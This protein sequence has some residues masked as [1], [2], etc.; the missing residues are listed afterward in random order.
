VFSLAR[1]GFSAVVKHL[2]IFQHDPLEDLGVFEQVLERYNVSFRHVRLYEGGTPT[3]PWDE[4]GALVILGGPMAVHEEENYPFLRLE[5]T[6]IRTAVKEGIPILGICLGAQLIA[7][8]TGAEVYRGNIQE[9]G[10]LPISVSLDGQMDP[11]LGYLP[12]KPTVFQWHGDGFDLPK[13]A[14]RLAS[15][16]YYQNQAFR[17]GKNIYGLQF[18]LEVTP[19]MIERWMNQRGKELAQ[20]PYISP[21]KIQVD[22]DSYSP[23]SKYY[24][25]RFFSEFLHRVLIQKEPKEKEQSAKA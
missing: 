11:L 9:I 25:E 18:H 2:L 6:I 21:D 19:T 17:I 4:V 3:E 15:S 5:K 24:G 8:A 16:L 20:I 23:T 7:A 1:L 13:G 10:W 14:K 12:G 22:T